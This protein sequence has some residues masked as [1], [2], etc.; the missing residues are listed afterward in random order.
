ME[1]E[2]GSPFPSRVLHSDL[3]SHQT[4]SM[5]RPLRTS[6]DPAWSY[7]PEQWDCPLYVDASLASDLALGSRSNMAAAAASQEEQLYL[8]PTEGAA[9][10]PSI[11]NVSDLPFGQPHQL[12]P[13]LAT[14][15][16]SAERTADSTIV[17]F[18]FDGSD[19]RSHQRASQVLERPELRTFG[20]QLPDLARRMAP[21]ESQTEHDGSGSWQG[22]FNCRHSLAASHEPYPMSVN[23]LLPV[24]GRTEIL[25]LT[26]EPLSSSRP[27]LHDAGD[28]EFSS[29]PEWHQKKNQGMDSLGG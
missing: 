26:P 13:H 27:P 7:E 25:A 4:G 6:H 10:L 29:N 3:H 18:I 19:G 1:R 9:A 15:Y 11:T 21:R 12:S 8:F 24:D 23:E 28:H 14:A 20:P 22:P 16:G 5:L 2:I 17:P